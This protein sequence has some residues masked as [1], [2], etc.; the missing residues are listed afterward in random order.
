MRLG[1]WLSACLTIS[2]FVPAQPVCPQAADEP[3]V[4]PVGLDAYRQWDQWYV[5][6]IGVRAYMRSTY[7][8]RGGNEGADASHFLYQLA[9]DRNVALDVAGPGVLYFVRTNHWHGSPWHYDID[10]RDH[11]IRETSTTDP[12]HPVPHS[13]F[14]PAALFPTPL[15]WTWATTKGAD[16]NGVPMAFERSLRLDYSRTH[17]GTGYFIYHQFVPGARLSHP[18]RAWDGRTPPDR[19]VLELLRHTGTA[20]VPQPGT[21]EGR[22]LG[23][24]ALA[25]RA[26]LPKE[27][28]VALA[29]I[30]RGPAL[31]RA[32]ELSVPRAQALAFGRARLRMTWDGRAQPSV[33]APVALFF[34][35]GTLYNRDNREYLVKAF[36]VQIRFA[37]DRVH[38]AC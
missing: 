10:G 4:I 38:L 29:R 7:D 17:Y 36:P 16:L 25:G 1:C 35:A 24:T 31:L 14:L 22:R 32:L 33:D 23:I 30:T 37:A 19:D 28:S 8:R 12:N 20:L 13:T 27:G 34:G 6:R 2:L 11:L 15:A 5:Q 3:P 18:L 9:G 26:D 21:P